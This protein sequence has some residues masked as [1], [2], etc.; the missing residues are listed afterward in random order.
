MKLGFDFEINKYQLGGM[1]PQL[2]LTNSSFTLS[3]QSQNCALIVPPF[4]TPSS[5]QEN[6][7][8]DIKCVNM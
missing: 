3:S 5:L 7:H 1:S 4:Y 8:I 2:L 6:E